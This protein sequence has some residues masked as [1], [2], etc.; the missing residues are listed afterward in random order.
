MKKWSREKK[1]GVAIIAVMLSILGFLTGMLIDSLQEEE[2]VPRVE[3]REENLPLEE[4]EGEPLQ[5]TLS[6]QEPSILPETEISMTTKFSRCGHSLKTPAPTGLVGLRKSEVEALGFEWISEGEGSVLLHGSINGYCPEHLVLCL[7]NGD[8]I[9]EK[10]SET[11]FSLLTQ[12]LILEDAEAMEPLL[13]EELRR[14]VE[15][16]SLSELDD[17]LESIET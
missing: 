16:R 5:A 9:V 10:R 17:Y 12:I 8:V 14:G 2:P 6:G 4:A 3:T 1:R 13:E 11:D 7:R 15:I